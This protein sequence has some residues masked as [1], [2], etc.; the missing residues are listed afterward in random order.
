MRRDI[1]QP[2]PR[3]Q[4]PQQGRGAKSSASSSTATT[5][6]LPTYPAP[7]QTTSTAR[8]AALLN[9]EAI[10]NPIPPAPQST[11]P[12]SRSGV[13]PC[14]GVCG[15]RR[16][17]RPAKGARRAMSAPPPRVSHSPLR[18]PHYTHASNFF[19]GNHTVVS[20]HCPLTRDFVAV[21][22][23]CSA[24]GGRTKSKCSSNGVTQV[25]RFPTPFQLRKTD[26]SQ[27]KTDSFQSK[28]DISQSVQL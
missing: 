8:W 7:N 15:A 6:T 16:A 13:M 4:R 25:C 18:A 11:V 3:L 14:G 24:T 17:V 12:L 19:P 21:G 27:S 20:V 26:I 2:D 9:D 22:G 5:A 23:G 28:T 1:F 10:P